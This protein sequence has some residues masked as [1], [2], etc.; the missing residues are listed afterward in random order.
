MK[1]HDMNNKSKYNFNPIADYYN[2]YHSAHDIYIRTI[3]ENYDIKDI[4]TII[5][6][7]CGT[8]IETI[9]LYQSFRCKIIGID[10]ARKMLRVGQKL[11]PNIDWKIGTAENIPLEGNSVDLITSFFSVHHFVNIDLS[12]HE[13]Y[14]V[15][16][17]NGKIFI[18][19][20][21]HSQMVSSLEYKFFPD[22]LSIDLKR[23]PSI[24]NLKEK[25]TLNNFNTTEV[26][27]KYETRK[28]DKKYLEMV[29]N[30]YRIGFRLLN[31]EQLNSGIKLVED[32]IS[33]NK[34]L[35]D[36][37]NCTVLISQ[38]NDNVS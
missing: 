31:Q 5:D 38:K 20:I 32:A 1:Y 4:I 28:I 18:F 22:M 10:P 15:L 30:K 7:G 19:T 8:G 37:I 9:N 12:F 26:E 34:N 11:L 27:I 14:R 25:L 35:T 24:V 13:F 17:P 16:K 6:I 3:R 29:K 2:K 33:K 21:S 36:S 23:V